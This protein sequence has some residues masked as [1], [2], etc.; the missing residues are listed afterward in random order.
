MKLIRFTIIA[1]SLWYLPTFI[2]SIFGDAIGSYSSYFMFI[3]ILGYY[4]LAPKIKPNFSLIILGMTYFLISGLSYTGEFDFFVNKFLKYLIFIIG[5]SELVTRCKSNLLFYFLLIGASSIIINAVFFP[6]FYGR[7]S[8][9][10]Q[11]PNLAGLLALIG[12]CFCFSIPKRLLRMIGFVV[13]IFAG[14]LTF[15]RYFILMW[16]ILSII[17]VFIDR[18]NAEALGIGLGSVI[19]IFGIASLLQLNTERFTA[20]ENIIGN[21]VDAGTRELSQG[22]RIETWSYFFEDILDNIIFGNGFTSMS[23]NFGVSVGVHN[24]LLLTL[25]EAG[26]I[27]FLIMILIF[28]RFLYLGLKKIR[29]DLFAFQLSMVVST[30]IFISHNFYDNYLLLFFMVWLSWYLNKTEESDTNKIEHTSEDASILR[31]L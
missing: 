9:F 30:Y 29:E 5:L 11:N 28:S 16:I 18:K 24:S 25:G 26:I 1:F 13:F 21:N 22:S 14:F 6:D 10:Y 15:S 19:V 2:L 7:Y 31:P 8:G 12:F 20:L 3:A 23:G 27:P 4:F 17:S